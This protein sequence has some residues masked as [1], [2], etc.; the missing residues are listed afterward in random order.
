VSNSPFARASSGELPLLCYGAD[1]DHWFIVWPCKRCAGVELPLIAR[2]DGPDPAESV[3][4]LADV[5]ESYACPGC[6]ARAKRR[7][8]SH[9]PQ[10]WWDPQASGWVVR[11]PCG[12]HG[13]VILPLDIP[14]YDAPRALIHCAAADLVYLGADVC[15]DVSLRD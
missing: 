3:P 5:P 4:D 13:S 12:P 7:E 10:V 9:G 14:W 1:A 6:L 11:I 8:T 15:D 2:L